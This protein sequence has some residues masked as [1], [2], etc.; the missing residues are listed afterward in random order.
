M[1]RK[2]LE[3]AYE[4]KISQRKP[5]LIGLILDD[6]G[7]MADK[8]PGTEDPKYRWVERYLQIILYELMALSS[9]LKGD[10]AVV[11]PRYFISAL[12]YGT[13]PKLWGNPEMDIQTALDLFSKSG[14]SLGLGGNLGGTDAEA[15]FT[16][17]LGHLKNSLA[18]E[19]FRNSFPPMI[20]H[21]SDGESGTDATARAEEM[22][23]QSTADGNAHL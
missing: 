15:A 17:M 21:L 10:D 1:N 9:D 14:K 16:E 6:S 11:K 18:G 22:K 20:F 12:A 2:E 3:M 8:L 4:Q 5:G 13:C 19:R 7:S 23:Q